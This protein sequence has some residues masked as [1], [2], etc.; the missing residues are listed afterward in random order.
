MSKEKDQL[1]PRSRQF[2]K[3]IKRALRPKNI[4]KFMIVLATIA[5]LATSLIPYIF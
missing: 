4:G 3:K 2:K 5:L 1:S